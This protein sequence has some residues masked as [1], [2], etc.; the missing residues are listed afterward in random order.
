MDV[1]RPA[2]G[3]VVLLDGGMGQ[4]LVARGIDTTKGLWSAQALIDQPDTVVAVHRAFLDAGAD[5]ITTNSYATTQRRLPEP[6][7]F[8][9]LNRAAGELAMR[10]RTESGRSAAIAGCLPPID[11]SYRPDLVRPESELVE[12]Y[13]AQ[14]EALAPYVDL[15][16]CETLSTVAEARAAARGAAATG[17]PIWVS[18]TLADDGSGTL[19][20]GES[21]AAAAAA[22]DGLGVAAL[23]A[24][25]SLPETLSAAMPALVAAAGDRPA[26]GYANGFTDVVG[27]VDDGRALPDARE[28]LD[29]ER[30]AAF[31]GQWL[32]AGARIVGGCCEVGPA[33]IAELRRRLDAR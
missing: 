22:L 33:H 15:F 5:V 30:Y 9:R 19:R 25:C 12:M 18:W 24:N 6:D 21:I 28:D 23:L 1:T 29:P 11:G 8:A 26:G 20:S 14:A 13:R 16:L 3:D 31:A 17:R 32:D 27:G 2:P 4:E 10:A 7:D